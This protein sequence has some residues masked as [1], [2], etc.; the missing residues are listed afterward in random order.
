M[1]ANELVVGQHRKYREG[2]VKKNR[3]GERYG[4]DVMN[5]WI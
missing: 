4:R 2:R 1:L 5:A 3:D